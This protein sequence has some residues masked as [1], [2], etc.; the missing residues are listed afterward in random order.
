MSSFFDVKCFINNNVVI[1]FL[2]VMNNELTFLYNFF[3]DS[4]E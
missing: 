1:L 3:G 4:I 2:Y